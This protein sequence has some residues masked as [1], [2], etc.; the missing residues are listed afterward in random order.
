MVQ[1]EDQVAVA[2]AQILGLL[3][4]VVL[5]LLVKVMLAEMVL[6][7]LLVQLVVAVLEE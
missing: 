1:Q 2:V 6:L 5:E 7:P 4:P 3:E